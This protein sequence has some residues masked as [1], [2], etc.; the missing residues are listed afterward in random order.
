MPESDL[1]VEQEINDT[2]PHLP[3]LQKE[4]RSIEVDA[5]EKDI[6]V[7]EDTGNDMLVEE[8]VEKEIPVVKEDLLAVSPTLIRR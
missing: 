5:I 7:R 4:V 6:V 1:A 8:I 3:S 2:P